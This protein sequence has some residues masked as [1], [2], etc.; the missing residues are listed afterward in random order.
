MTDHKHR[1]TTDGVRVRGVIKRTVYR[2]RRHVPDWDRLTRPERWLTLLAPERVTSDVLNSVPIPTDRAV[3]L[4]GREVPGA[5]ETTANTTTETLS[6][7]IAVVLNPNTTAS[8]S[9]VDALA[10]GSDGG[11]GVAATDTS[12]NT[13]EGIIQL[14]LVRS[15]SNAA[16]SRNLET[17]AFLDT[18]QLNGNDLDELGLVLDVSGS[19]VLNHAT[20]PTVSKTNQKAVTFSVTIKFRAQ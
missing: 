11:S 5:T 9:T 12:L 10:L 13:Q 8:D 16:D 18:T 2:P 6:D 4:A 3:Q 19:D 7:L 1:Q 15:P 20:F 17:Q 14:S